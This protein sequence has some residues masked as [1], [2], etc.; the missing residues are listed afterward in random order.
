MLQ[1]LGFFFGLPGLVLRSGTIRQEQ[2]E[3]KA[4]DENGKAHGQPLS[5]LTRRI[6]CRPV[7]IVSGALQ[8][9]ALY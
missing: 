1:H 9:S 8:L 6:E 4:S 7:A 2:G 5:L 3:S